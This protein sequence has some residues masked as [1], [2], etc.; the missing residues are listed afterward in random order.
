MNKYTKGYIITF[1]VLIMTIT[2]GA[3]NL[4]APYFQA[5]VGFAQIFAI[6]ACCIIGGYEERAKEVTD[7]LK[8]PCK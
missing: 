6:C 8:V 5:A 1:I 2:I 7:P 4:S 3:P